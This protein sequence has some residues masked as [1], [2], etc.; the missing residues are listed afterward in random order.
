[1][2]EF[3]L[4]SI[5]SFSKVF[6]SIWGGALATQ[7][8]ELFEF[9][10]NNQKELHSPILSLFS[11]VTKYKSDRNRGKLSKWTDLNQMSYGVS[12]Y[13]QKI[14]RISRNII[15]T[16]IK[17]NAIEKRTQNYQYMLDSFPDR[18]Y[19]QGL[20]YSG[21]VPYVLPFRS[22]SKK[23]DQLVFMLADNDIYTGVYQF[24]INRNLFNPL[25]VPV[26]WLPIHQGIGINEMDLICSIIRQ[27][28]LRCT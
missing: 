27:W 14:S 13:A 7:S 11:H 25:F 22:E 23:L 18:P 4:G 28:E 9:S 10:K 5:Y 21:V 2:G 24:D 6:P 1:M 26:V 12:E 3:G 8:E 20:E 15:S 19:F 16:G 17:N